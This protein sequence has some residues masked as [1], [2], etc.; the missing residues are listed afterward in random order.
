MQ[1]FRL[2]YRFPDVIPGAAVMCAESG[3]VNSNV[4][5][6]VLEEP[7]D[8]VHHLAYVGDG[9]LFH[10]SLDHAMPGKIRVLLSFM[11]ASIPS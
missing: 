11:C 8:P 2:P 6:F 9:E 7:G 3:A 10:T 4:H 1:S 5:L